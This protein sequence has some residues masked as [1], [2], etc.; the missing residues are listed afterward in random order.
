MPTW[1]INAMKAVVAEWYEMPAMPMR[2][3]TREEEAETFEAEHPEVPDWCWEHIKHPVRQTFMWARHEFV[4][5]LV[6][7]EPSQSVRLVQDICF[8]DAYSDVASWH[9]AVRD[10]VADPARRVWIVFHE[11]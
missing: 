8:K 2:I 9:A 11:G 5:I 3:L 4:D 10:I 7:N 1:D 6:W